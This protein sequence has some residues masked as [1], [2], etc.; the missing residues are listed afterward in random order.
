M[1]ERYTERAR[2][3]LFFSRA[4]VAEHGGTSIEPEHILLGLLRD[5]RGMISRVCTERK[6]SA[7]ALQ[8]AIGQQVTRGDNRVPTSV[9]IPFSDAT[10]RVL[11]YAADE[12]DG[13][14]HGHIGTEHLLL[15]VLREDRSAAA[16]TLRSHGIKLVETRETIVNLLRET[17]APAGGASVVTGERVTLVL[18]LGEDLEQLA[19]DLAIAR[20][21]L[22]RIA[23]AL[24][25]LGRDMKRE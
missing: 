7:L 14:A 8:E 6:V 24:E 13:L 11:H 9:E 25:A 19:S 16:A 3:A 4:E 5:P 21:R 1:F 10:K 12:A 17:P 18:R 15:A 2:R 22:R 23:T 20:E